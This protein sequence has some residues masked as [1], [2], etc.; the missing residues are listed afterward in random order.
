MIKYLSNILNSRNPNLFFL[1]V[2]LYLGILLILYILYKISAPPKQPGEGFTQKEQFVLKREGDIYDDF[3]AEVY[4]TLNDSHARSQKELMEMI[5]MTEPSTS[6]SVFLDIGSGTGHAVHELREAGYR[7]YGIDKSKAMVDQCQKLYPDVEIKCEDAMDS[8][9]YEKGTFTHILCTNMTIYAIQDKATF[10][11]NC[12]SW[13]MPNG[14]LIIHL[15]DRDRFSMT[16]PRPKATFFEMS[17]PAQRKRNTDSMMDYYDF[18]YNASYK[19]PDH[20]NKTN[21]ITLKQSFTDKE[22]KHVR[23]NEETL[24]MDSIDEILAI[25]SRAGFILHGKTNMARCNG[26]QHQYLYVLERQQ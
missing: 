17:F 9:C 6:N 10:F 1:K 11:R 22:T 13:M 8:M 5:E 3:Y 19:F 16:N 12:H 24:Y 15:A 2:T 26:D 23:Q 7:A 20:S 4:D 25:A 14:Y 21:T 18:K